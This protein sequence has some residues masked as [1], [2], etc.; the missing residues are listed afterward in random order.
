MDAAFSVAK[1]LMQKDD[2]G[3]KTFLTPTTGQVTKIV[4]SCDTYVMALHEF[5]TFAKTNEEKFP[6][7]KT[8]PLAQADIDKLVGDLAIIK[9]LPY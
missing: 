2:K 8:M 6:T 1:E 5:Y 4:T 7:I 9:N 3:K